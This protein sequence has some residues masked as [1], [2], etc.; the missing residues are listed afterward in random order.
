MSDRPESPRGTS[1][2]GLLRYKSRQPEPVQPPVPG[3]LVELIGGCQEIDLGPRPVE[4][5]EQQRDPDRVEGPTRRAVRLS[6][7]YA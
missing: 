4:Q 2:A 5:F 7:Y 6:I 3:R 1:V